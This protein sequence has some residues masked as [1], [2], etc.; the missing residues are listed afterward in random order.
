MK[1]LRTGTAKFD[2]IRAK[3]A[4]GLHLQ[5]DAGNGLFI[6]DGG[7]VGIGTTN[8]SAKLDIQ[9]SSNTVTT[10]KFYNG[11]GSAPATVHIV[12]DGAA[13]DH[14]GLFVGTSDLSSAVLITKQNNV[15]IGTTSPGGKLHVTDLSVSI[16]SV[17]VTNTGTGVTGGTSLNTKIS[18]GDRIKINNQIFTVSA[19]ADTTL[20]LSGTPTTAGTFTAY[21]DSNALFVTSS[22]NV[23]IGTTSPGAK[24]HLST[25]GA[26]GLRLA[27]DS[28]TYYHM[29]RPNGDGLYL[30]AD[31]GGTGGV[32]ADI[33]FSVKGDE[34][35][36]ID[37][38]GNVGIGATS[39]GGK[40]HVTNLSVSIGNVTVTNTGTGVTGGTSLNTKIS[41]GDRIKINNQIFTVSAVAD[42]TLTLSGTP[43]TAGT[44]T[45]YTDSNALF[46]TSS[47]NV[48]IGTTSPGAKLHLSTAGADGLR[49]A[50]DSQTYYHMI[51]PNGDGLYLGADDGGTGGVGADIRFSVKGDEKMR[52]DSAGKLHVNGLITGGF[53]ARSTTTDPAYKDWNHASNARGGMGHYL[54]F[55]DD[56]NGPEVGL[57]LGNRYFH[58]FNFEYGSKDGT[59]SLT[60]WAI[61]YIQNLFYMR[62]RYLGTW[63]AWTAI[64]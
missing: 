10:S 16:G 63:T 7:N 62:T 9:S 2:T 47:G 6:K 29:I 37:S 17:T 24:L 31:D 39:P 35:M 15:G 25:A 23:G 30:G 45:A 40:L 3:D 55:G 53:G 60:Q 51:R 48:G 18:N 59:G 28:Q 57:G 8:P 14:V 56:T 26:D 49:L 64:I 21:T 20:T 50:V 5:D 13:S 11:G 43:T 41:N 27:V 61:G 33:R 19:V 52:I 4:N 32:G 1:N 36:R 22:G 46:V 12:E 42:T 54:L 38:A 34:K 58:I 44:F